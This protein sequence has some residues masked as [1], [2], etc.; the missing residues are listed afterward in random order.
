MFQSDRDGQ[1]YADLYVMDDT[2]ANVVRL[3][4]DGHSQAAA[5]SPDG[6]KIAFVSDRNGNWDVFVMNA[7]GSD[8]TQVSTAGV[9]VRVS[10]SPDGSQIVFESAL[11]IYKVNVDGTGET[12]LTVNA[13]NNMR[14]AWSP[15]ARL[16]QP[17][18]WAWNPSA[19]SWED[20]WGHAVDHNAP[21]YDRNVTVRVEYDKAGRRTALVDPRY[22]ETGY[23]YDQLNRRTALTDPLSHRWQTGYEDLAGGSS[24]ITL[25][26]PASHVTRREFDRLG[27][28]KTIDYLN[29]APG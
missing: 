20:G 19:Q 11:D 28:L 2:G 17:E 25:T 7:D 26:D 8:Q 13:A 15:V 14:P 27:R 4:T 9:C 23:E 5:W 3:T 16:I 1:N 22:N 24:R 29:E 10:W 21:V 18:E 12:R 6:E